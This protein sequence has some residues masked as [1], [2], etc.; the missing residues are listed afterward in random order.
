M[1]SKADEMDIEV[2]REMISRFDLQKINL[3]P[4]YNGKNLDFFKEVVFIDKDTILSANPS[5]KDIFS[6]QVAN[7]NF[8]GKLTFMSNGDIFSGVNEP[9]VGNITKD[10]IY[11]VCKSS[12]LRIIDYFTAGFKRGEH[13]L[14]IC[15]A[16]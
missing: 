14:N 4:Y 3:K 9:C 12:T 13:R 16:R 6:R 10:S 8:F 5:Q 1:T 11:M 7:K 2:C 15:A